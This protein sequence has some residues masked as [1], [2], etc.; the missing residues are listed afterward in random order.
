MEYLLSEELRIFGMIGGFAVVLAILE[1]CLL[2][3]GF[4]SNLDL[5]D[6]GDL[7]EGPAGFDIDVAPG[8]LD[9]LSSSELSILD[10]PSDDGGDLLARQKSRFRQL[11][12]NFG[13]GN[14]PL[15]I[16]LACISACV[17]SLGFILQSILEGLTGMLP[18]WLALVVVLI[19][20]LRMA[21][22]MSK[23]VSRLIPQVETYVVS[24]DRFNGR[25]GLVSTGTAMIGRPAE[26]RWFDQHGTLHNTMA[27][28]L[29]ADQSI[30]EGTEVLLLRTRTGEARIISID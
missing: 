3:L 28:P 14:G 4:S 17:S 20:G 2:F 19:P 15:L 23:W 1:M 8:D 13:I 27:E 16:G 21:G 7:A 6:V 10:L 26:V 5:D 30:G 25:R 18:G 22:G 12:A 9:A 29:R 11:L 24:G